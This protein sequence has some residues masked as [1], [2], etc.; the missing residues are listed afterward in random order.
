MSD[1]A[2]WT[3]Y[4]TTARIFGSAL[5]ERRRHTL[6]TQA[7]MAE[8]LGITQASYSRL[9]RGASTLTVVQLELAAPH[10]GRTAAD[11]VVDAIAVEKRARHL[12][13]AVL[14][15]APPDRPDV[16]ELSDF[17]LKRIASVA[18]TVCDD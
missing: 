8:A 4:V 6:M 2:Q 3:V 12:G 11:L 15:E 14:H 10:V 17:E 16:T 7:L 1:P 9:E 5:R 13:F 18:L